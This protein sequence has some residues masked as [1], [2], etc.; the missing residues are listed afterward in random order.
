MA[1]CGTEEKRDLLEALSATGWLLNAI[2]NG[3]IGPLCGALISMSNHLETELRSFVLTSELQARV[4]RALGSPFSGKTKHAARSICLLGGFAALGGKAENL[5]QPAFEEPYT[6]DDLLSS[7][8][9]KRP[10]DSLGMYELQFW[11]GLKALHEAGLAPEVIAADSG[12]RFIRLLMSAEPPTEWARQHQSDLLHWLRVR[13]AQGWR[14][15][16]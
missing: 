9:K 5:P 1:D 11:F 16:D 10:S 12:T 6:A 14:L 2:D 13:E 3:L 8:H 7:L 4:G 15:K